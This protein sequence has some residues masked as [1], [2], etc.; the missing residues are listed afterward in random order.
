MNKLV[1]LEAPETETAR[2][3]SLTLKLFVALL[4]N[5]CI[6]TIL[7]KGNPNR[8]S[9]GSPADPIFRYFGVLEGTHGDFG[10]EWYF[11]VCST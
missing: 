1:D 8:V 5:T 9:S 10:M 11:E 7:I 6:I 2:I 4:V 3:V